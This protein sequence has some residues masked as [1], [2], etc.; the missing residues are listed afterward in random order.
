MEALWQAVSKLKRRE[1]FGAMYVDSLLQSQV[2]SL[3]ARLA[4]RAETEGRAFNENM[5]RL[6]SA[7]ADR[8]SQQIERLRDIAWCLRAEILG[9]L[10]K[11]RA[12]T[13]SSGEVLSAQALHM[14]RDLNAVLNSIDRM[15]VRGRDSA[16]VSLLFVLA[17]PVYERLAARLEQEALY[18]EWERRG[19]I[20][21][22]LNQSIT[23]HRGAESVGVAFTYKVAVEIGRL[24][25]NIRFLRRQIASDSIL[26][27]IAGVPAEFHTINAH[28]R[29]ASVGA[30]TEANCHPVDNRVIHATADE[31]GILHTCLNGDIDNFHELKEAFERS[32]RR[33]HADVTTDTKIIPLQIEHYLSQGFGVEESFRR[34]VNDFKGSHAIAMHTS[35]AP[36]RLF[37]A[38]K[39]SGQAVFIGIADGH[40]MPTS[41][42]YGFIEETQ[43]YIKLDGESVVEG[44]SGKTQ[45]QIAVLDQRSTGGIDGLRLI[46][47]DGTPVALGAKNLKRT[48]LTSRDIDRQDYPHYFLKEISESPASVEKTLQNRWKIQ[49]NGGR[50]MVVALD[51]RVI[52][53][54]IDSALSHGAIRRIFFIGQ[55]TAGVA[56]LACAN[57]LGSYLNDPATS[58]QALKASE[59]SGFA[60]SEEADDRSMADALVIAIS[61]SGTTTDTN[62]SVDMAR[63]R[64]ANTIAIV[65]RRDSDLT[66][67]VQGVMY[68]SSGRD[69]EMSV[70]S[71]K[72]FYA[73]IVAGA[74]LGLRI[75]WLT[76]RRDEA[77][78]SA[79]IERLLALPGHMRRVLA[80]VR[81]HP[82]LGPAPGRDQDVLGRGGQRPQQG[83]GRRDPHQT[84]RA[85]LQNHLIG[86]RRRQKTYRPVFGAADYRLRG[87]NPADR[88]RRHHQGHRHIQGA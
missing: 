85:L 86:L 41:E 42:V 51:E 67:K 69:I 24:G 20:E 27:A 45:G 31:M 60:L 64:G 5:G 1:S 83:L 61:Q 33:I 25:D 71:T 62:R 28:T 29:W 44:K 81:A 26:Q 11:V 75:A 65:N 79:E 12:L 18:A 49:E 53:P 78:V 40:Y 32:G 46:Y 76:G 36:G 19:R 63:Q 10:A 82:G 73:Q 43:A 48:A 84:Q 17:P 13:A 70:A 66:F 68:T 52:P 22:L 8:M 72:A 77:F 3:A 39:G 37:L 14:F 58:V 34:A 59:F 30:I 6:S 15:E 56:A 50:R 35:L 57:I 87:R 21:P 7:D 2:E 80:N 74:L 23:V 9:N 55:G 16:G 47:Y 88:H 54:A 4:E 38:Q